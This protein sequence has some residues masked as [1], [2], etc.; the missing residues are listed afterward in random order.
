MVQE[1]VSKVMSA[2]PQ[3]LKEGELKRRQ[4]TSLCEETIPNEAAAEEK[5]S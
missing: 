5:N 4:N 1:S 2:K 3:Q